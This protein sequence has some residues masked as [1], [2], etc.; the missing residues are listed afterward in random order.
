M[1]GEYYFGTTFS[2][3]LVM[4][5]SAVLFVYVMLESH[6]M[7][8]RMTHPHVDAMAGDEGED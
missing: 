6:G 1:T 3:L 2:L 7:V 5:I 4:V 8:P